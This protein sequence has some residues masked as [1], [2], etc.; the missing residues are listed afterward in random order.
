[1]PWT[2]Q[3]KQ[4]RPP[5]PLRVAVPHVRVPRLPQP[6]EVRPP[7]PPEIEGTL[8]AGGSR[9]RLPFTRVKVVPHP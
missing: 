4:E 7:K 3:P 6:K 9:C 8:G 5:R 2:Q 1:M